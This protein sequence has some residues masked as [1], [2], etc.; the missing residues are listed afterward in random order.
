MFAKQTSPVEYCLGFY[1]NGGGEN[2]LGMISMRG[3]NIVFDRTNNRIGIAESN[4][5]LAHISGFLDFGEV[6][7]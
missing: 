3:Q 4:C 7:V 5:D 2:V 6:S 1:A